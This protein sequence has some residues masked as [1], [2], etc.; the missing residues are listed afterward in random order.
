M[1]EAK[2]KALAHQKQAIALDTF[3]GRILVLLH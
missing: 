3:G 2:R 1:G